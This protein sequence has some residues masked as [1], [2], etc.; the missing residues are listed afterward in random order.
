MTDWVRANSLS[1]AV[2]R[3]GHSYEGFSQSIDV[4]IDLR[5]LQTSPWTPAQDW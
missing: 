4:V 2:R 1:F 3:G 5:G